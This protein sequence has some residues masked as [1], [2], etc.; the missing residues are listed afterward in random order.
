MLFSVI[1]GNMKHLILLCC[2]WESY[3]PKSRLYR[4]VSGDSRVIRR[5][6]FVI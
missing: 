6:L 1:G 5:D 3:F 4:D 2:H